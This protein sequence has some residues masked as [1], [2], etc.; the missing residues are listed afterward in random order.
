MAGMNHNDN[1]IAEMIVL[2]IAI[3]AGITTGTYL[4]D[5]GAV[6]GLVMF[7]GL[8]VALLVAVV[9]WWITDQVLNRR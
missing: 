5:A 6:F 2:I 9:L 4:H 3:I 8:F 1:D 7:A